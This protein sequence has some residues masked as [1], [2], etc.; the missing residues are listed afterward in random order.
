M[1]LKEELELIDSHLAEQ[2][3]KM[4]EVQYVQF[5]TQ[6]TTVQSALTHGDIIM[7][8]MSHASYGT[9]HHTSNPVQER[10]LLWHSPCLVTCVLCMCVLV[11]DYVQATADETALKGGMSLVNM[12]I[13][14][15][16]VRQTDVL[17]HMSCVSARPC[18]LD[19][20]LSFW[21]IYFMLYF[22]DRNKLNDCYLSGGN[23][24]AVGTVR[25]WL[26][27]E[28]N[29]YCTV[30]IKSVHLKLNEHRNSLFLHFS[31]A[32]LLV[33]T[34]GCNL[35]VP[36]PKCALGVVLYCWLPRCSLAWTVSAF[37]KF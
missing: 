21:F 28:C 32:Y 8:L 12:S 36:S 31:S 27:M 18:T 26:M 5:K 9:T 2:R 4:L 35:E 25:A 33:D 14:S 19:S 7:L 17:C 30:F 11:L 22:Y 3:C 29:D 37:F 10:L 24:Q 34:A 6:W 23:G 15:L 16:Q 1:L 20:V 13:A